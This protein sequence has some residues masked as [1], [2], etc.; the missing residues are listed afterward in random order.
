MNFVE[1][2]LTVEYCFGVMLDHLLAAR[3][4]LYIVFSPRSIYY[5]FMLSM[6]FCPDF[7]L[8]TLLYRIHSIYRIYSNTL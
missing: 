4:A 6:P 5:G 8:F 1:I 3:S 2:F 7:L